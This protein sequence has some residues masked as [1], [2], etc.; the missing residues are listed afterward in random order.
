MPAGSHQPSHSAG[1]ET[2]SSR[3]GNG[4]RAGSA[5][6]VQRAYGRASTG[7][8]AA[9]ECAAPMRSTSA[10]CESTSDGLLTVST[11]SEGR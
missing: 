4:R 9:H 5:S 2:G 8:A 3:T 10:L 11:L 1:V 7:T 6:S